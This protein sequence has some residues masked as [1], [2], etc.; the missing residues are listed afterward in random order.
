[1]YPQGVPFGTGAVTD[2]I[3]YRPQAVTLGMGTTDT[4][5]F[6]DMAAAHLAEAGQ[7]V[8]AAVLAE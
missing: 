1:M 8:Q 3:M 7:A 5:G 4:A 2:T 6:T